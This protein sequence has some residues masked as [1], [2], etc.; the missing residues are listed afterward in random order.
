MIRKGSG[1]ALS[2]VNFLRSPPVQIPIWGSGGHKVF[3][4]RG[5]PLEEKTFLQGKSIVLDSRTLYHPFPC[6]GKSSDL[7]DD[8]G[9]KLE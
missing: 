5:E 7:K 2:G 1:K 4:I 9:I 8:S 6:V 3:S